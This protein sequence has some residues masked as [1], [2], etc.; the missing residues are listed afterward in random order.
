MWILLLVISTS[1][2]TTIT[3]IV[4]FKN[5]Q[6]CEQERI[7]LTEEFDTSYGPEERN[8]EFICKEARKRMEAK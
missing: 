6:E 3:P 5:L 4:N 7:R 1:T 2:F 8:Y